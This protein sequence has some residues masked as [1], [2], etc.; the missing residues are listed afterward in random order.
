[1]VRVLAVSDVRMSA[2]VC[3]L[4]Y[5]RSAVNKHV[6]MYSLNKSHLTAL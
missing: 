3:R 5:C 1:M 4:V 2:N 6:D